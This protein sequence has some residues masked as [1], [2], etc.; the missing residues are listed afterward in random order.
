MIIEP[1]QAGETVRCDCGR[2]STAPA[3]GEIRRLHPA[4]QAVATVASKWEGPQRFLVI[5][6]L[7]IVVAAVAAA[8]LFWQYPSEQRI[9]TQIERY[10]RDVQ[11]LKPWEAIQFYRRYLAPGIER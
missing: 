4:A 1:R 6:L 5:G 9:A 11:A 8:V 7:L 2:V 10:R 3:M